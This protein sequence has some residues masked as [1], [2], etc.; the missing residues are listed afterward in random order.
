MSIGGRSRLHYGLV[1]A[2]IL[3]LSALVYWCGFLEPFERDLMDARFRSLQRMPSGSL[4]LVEIDPRSLRE[5][6]SWPWPRA[7]H[8]K[9]LDALFAAGARRVALDIDLSSHSGAAADGSLAAAFERHAGRVILPTFAQSDTGAGTASSTVQTLPDRRFRGATTIG[10]VNVYPAGDSL[11]RKFPYGEDFD[12]ATIPSLASEL[13][14]RADLS[15][16]QFYLDYGIEIGRMPRLS[17][18]DVLNGTFDPQ[19]VAGRNV[20]VGATAVELGDQFAVPVYRTLAG[21]YVQALAYESIIQ[22]RA[23]RRT[24]ALPSLAGAALILAVLSAISGAWGWRRQVGAL[25]IIWASLY[26]LAFAVAARAPVSVDIGL[27][28]F[29][30]LAYCAYGSMRQFEQQARLLVRQRLSDMRRRALI[31]CVLEDSFDGILVADEA[32][33]VEIAN[34]AAGRLIGEAAA[35]RPIGEFFPG[36]SP[37]PERHAEWWHPEEDF[38]IA[39]MAPVATELA[40]RGGANLPV[41]L[42]ISRS[43]LR[44]G[45]RK[46]DPKRIFLTYTFRDISERL[47]TERALRT[48]MREALAANRAKSE[49]LANMGH[50]LR[51]PL[52]AVIGFSEMI[53]AEAFGKLPHPRYLEYAGDIMNSGRRLLDVINDILSMSQCETGELRIN[54]DVVDLHDLVDNCLAMIRGN[55]SARELTIARET[56][57]QPARIMGDARLLRQVFLNVLSNAVKFTP[58]GGTVRVALARTEPGLVIRVADTGI[59]IAEDEIPRV[60]RPF[61]QVDAKLARRYE[62]T[63]L[64]LT[65]ACAYMQLHQGETIIESVLGAGTTVSLMFPA[66]RIVPDQVETSGAVPS[67][68]G[69]FTSG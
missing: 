47:K 27:P 49:F 48:S 32:G 2:V 30:A 64:G 37:I 61:Y 5:L 6:S 66:S 40:R 56:P 24:G 44:L 11:I 52:N 18:V 35:G 51:T 8:A 28:A 38:A 45:G 59:G 42:V 22:H 43:R 19:V 67:P 20:L 33:V 54:E 69:R 9:I 26:A 62:G 15:D 55:G 34:S 4:V 50:E 39:P 31:Q 14:G 7:Y 29:A 12:S 46:R 16:R 3:L 60:V 25:A 13:A 23:L 17:Y 1:P 57:T 36:S 65:L 58:P 41:E 53:H 63:G 68:S 21:P 10:A